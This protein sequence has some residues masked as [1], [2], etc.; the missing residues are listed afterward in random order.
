ME[1]AKERLPLPDE[2]P[3]DTFD[4]DSS[5]TTAQFQGEIGVTGMKN[6]PTEYFHDALGL[7]NGFVPHMN[8]TIDHFGDSN[9]SDLRLAWHQLADITIILSRVFHADLSE[10]RGGGQIIADQVGL[11]KTSTILGLICVLMGRI[12]LNGQ[13]IPND[14]SLF[15]KPSDSIVN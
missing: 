12:I 1:M 10:P 6:K 5:D 13:P 15:S 7:V 14:R 4:F 2:R 3:G 11:G 8:R 9:T